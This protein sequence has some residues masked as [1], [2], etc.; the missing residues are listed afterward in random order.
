MIDIEEDSFFVARSKF[1]CHEFK[2]YRRRKVV[3]TECFDFV[4][5]FNSIQ[6][7]QCQITTMASET[8]RVQDGK[9]QKWEEIK[10]SESVGY[11]QIWHQFSSKWPVVV[12]SKSIYRCSTTMMWPFWIL[13]KFKIFWFNFKNLKMISCIV[14]YREW[15]RMVLR[16]TIVS[17]IF[18]AISFLCENLELA[19]ELRTRDCLLR[20]YQRKDVET[21]QEQ[22][23]KYL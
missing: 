6:N 21:M 16:Y 20:W 17:I 5:W 8:W 23:K 15:C 11:S 9:A 4:E 13:I 2:R 10:L 19:L 12:V 7:D 1:S 18:F 14:K 22:Q 3:S